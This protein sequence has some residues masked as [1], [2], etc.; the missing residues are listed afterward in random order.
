[1]KGII[2]AAGR[3]SRMGS[4]TDNFPKCRTILHGK[5]LITWQMDAL[6]GAGIDE[7]AIVRGYLANSFDFNV[8]YFENNRWEETNMVLSLATA[9]HWLQEEPCIVSY[10]DI[11]YSSDAVERLAKTSGDICI[12]YDPNWK[13]LWKMRFED[14]LT[15]AETFKLDGNR[16]VEIGN[17]ATTM[18]EIEGQYM[19]LL[20]F[21]PNGWQQ[22]TALLSSLSQKE[23]DR[24]D[25][26]SLLRALI[27]NDGVVSGVPIGDRWY[28]VDSESDL[29]K[30]AT[31]QSLF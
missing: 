26:T 25:A 27:R 11:V 23:Q 8:H 16:V 30:Y 2:L 21:T 31:L 20:R 13:T 9:K 29:S 18:D 28:E 22:V 19:G 3:G 5:E 4:L 10:S 6:Y 24:L 12:T 15:D 1:M 7:I 14:P 17:K